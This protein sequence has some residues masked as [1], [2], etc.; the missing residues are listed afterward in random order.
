[1][2]PAIINSAVADRLSF[3]FKDRSLELWNRTAVIGIL[4]VTPDSFYDGG[5]HY[6]L[7]AAVEHGCKLAAE[8][9][10]VI[11]VGGES[12]RPG[13]REITVEEEKARVVPVIREL[14]GRIDV[15]ISIDTRKAGVAAAAI[16]A[17]AS[18]VN[19]VSALSHDPGMAGLVA[20]EKVGV[21]L[22]HMKG[23]PETMQVD[24]T[25]DS[26]VD[27]I[28]EYLSGRVDY[29]LSC[30]IDR[31]RI[32]IDPGI[33]FGKACEHNLEIIR[34]LGSFNGFG[35][36]VVVGPSR[37]SFI[38]AVLDL[39][40]GNRLMGTASAVALAVANGA[41]MIR[42]HDVGAMCRVVRMA[43]AIAGR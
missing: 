31:E 21:I 30:G 40:V 22:M 34:R 39:P 25:Y 8:G 10:D 14:A 27:E 24:P 15:P 42:V 32:A 9:A 1:M 4:N 3:S 33:G 16:G 2:M 26:V 37:K 20:G 28:L 19:D 18:I 17:G 38:G 35:R 11:D 36:P 5:R 41:R 12:T 13:A 43:E 7:R 29:A 23:T 6:G